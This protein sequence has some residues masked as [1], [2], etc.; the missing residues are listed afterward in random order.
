MHENEIQDKAVVA[1]AETAEDDLKN[2]F[3]VTDRL[4]HSAFVENRAIIASNFMANS[5]IASNRSLNVVVVLCLSHRV[6]FESL[7]S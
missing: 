5:S 7:C 3:E 6:I 1:D 2:T 4:R